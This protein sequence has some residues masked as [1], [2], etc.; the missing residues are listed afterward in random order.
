M[1]PGADGFRPLLLEAPTT[2]PLAPLPDD[3]RLGRLLE[4][5]GKAELDALAAIPGG[6]APGT[7][8]RVHRL[9]DLEAIDGSPLAGCP[10]VLSHLVEYQPGELAS[11]AAGLAVEVASP[12]QLAAALASPADLLIGTGLE[13]P[14]PA[15]ET[16][17]MV[18][19]QLLA[20]RA[21]RP[22]YLAIPASPELAAALR[23]EGASGL[24]L[25]ANLRSRQESLSRVRVP[26]GGGAVLR[27]AMAADPE[28]LRDLEAR[29]GRELGELL[30]TTRSEGLWDE[31]LEDVA[32]SDP[33]C[34]V[35]LAQ[36]FGAI[37]A[38]APCRSLFAAGAPGG[39]REPGRLPVVQGPLSRISVTAE[40]AAAVHDAGAFPYLALAGL[41]FETS[42]ALVRETRARGF[43]FGVGIV[44]LAEDP[45]GFERLVRMLEE[46]RPDRVLVA[47]P[48]MDH[49]DRL[50]ATGLELWV[51]A[52]VASVFRALASMGVTR[53]VV[54]GEE[55][56]G[57]VSAT[58]A[59]VAWDQVLREVRAQGLADRVEI[60]FAGGVA[61]GRAAHLLSSLLWFHG[62]AGRLRASLHVGT[63]YLATG[64]IVASTPLGRWYQKRVVEEDETFVTGDTLRLRVR[65][66]RTSAVEELRRREW[67]VFLSDLPLEAKRKEI[68]RGYL[69]TLK[70]ALEADG[71]DVGASFMAGSA[72]A[73]ITRCRSLRELHEELTRDRLPG[74][75]AGRPEPIAV[76]GIGALL[77]GARD[78]AGFYRSVLR[79][80]CFVRDLP[81]SVW[82]RDV[83]LD[84]DA[85]APLRSYSGIA[86]LVGEIPF[87]PA[88]FRIPPSAAV[89]MDRAQK[90][91][92]VCAR[93]ALADA[94]Y[95]ERRF[96]RERVGVILANSMGGNAVDESQQTVHAERVRARLRELAR[97]KGA[98]ELVDELL[99]AYQDRFEEPEITEDTL[100]G[101]LSSLIA[102]RIAWA[103]D[104]HGPNFTVDSAC[105][106][107][108]AAVS[109][110][111][112]A[113]RARECDMVLSGGV[114]TQVDPGLFVKFSKLTA[115]SAEGSFPFDARA[116]GFVIGEGCAVFALKRWQDALLAGDP[117]YAVI[118]GFGASSDGAGKGITAP[119]TEGQLLAMTR[120]Y[121]DAGIDPRELDYVECHGT[122]TRLGD[123]T[124]LETVARL[125]R[126]RDPARGALPVGSV[127]A[128]VG[129]LKAAAGAAGLVQGLMA[130]N[131]RSVP[132]QVG[133]ET[134]NPNVAWRE[135]GIRVATRPESLPEDRPVK[136]GV[137]SFGFGGTNYHL[138]LESPPAGA[139]PARV[140][141]GRYAL[142]EL[143]PLGRDLALMFPGQGSQYLGM[144]EALRAAP[145][146]AEVLAEA[147]RCFRA[148]EG[149]RIS[150]VIWPA[151]RDAAAEVRLTDTR[152]AQPAIFTVSVMLLRELEAR[153]VRPALVMGHSL[154][155]YTALHA[156]G[157]LGFEDA[158]RAVSIRGR[159]M[160]EGAGADPG[161]MAFVAADEE[162][163]AGLLAG[164]SGYVVAANLN[165][166]E[167]TV[168]S[169][170]TAAVEAVVEAAERRGV[171]ARRLGV[172][173]AFHSRL[174][175]G[176]IPRMREVLEAAPLRAGAL[177]VPANLAGRVYPRVAAA[178]AGRPLSAGER[179]EVVELLTRQIDHPVDFVRQVEA[180]Y[181]AGI[182]RFLEVGPKNV[183]ARLVE[184]ILAGKA[185]TA[186]ATDKAGEEGTERFEAAVAGLGEP[187]RIARRPR[188]GEGSGAG[189]GARSGGAAARAA[190][191]A[192]AGG[193]GIG[194]G[195]GAGSQPGTEAGTPSVEARV[196][197]VVAS[198]SGYRA[199][200]IG[201]DAD[202]ERD[203]GIDTLKIFEILSR[204]RGEVLPPGTR[205]FRDLTTV[206]KIV[207]AAGPGGG[208]GAPATAGPGGVP[209]GEGG[210]FRVLVRRE[211][212][213]VLPAGPAWAGDAWVE[214]LPA[215][216]EPLRD[217]LF[218]RLRDRLAASAPRPLG[219][220]TWS[221][222]GTGSRA[223]RLAVAGFVRSAAKDVGEDRI[224][225]VH[226]E[227]DEPS[228]AAAAAALAAPGYGNRVVGSGKVSEARLVAVEAGLAPETT[229]GEALGP[230]DLILV[231]GGARGIAAEVVRRWLGLVDSRFVVLGR[232]PSGE[233]WIETEGR[234]RVRYVQADLTTSTGVAALAAAG[235]APTLVV[236]ASG[237]EVSRALAGKSDEE[238]RAVIDSKVAALDALS[239]AVRR[240][241]LR[242]VV[243]FSSVASHFGNH[244][245]AD[246]AAANGWLDGIGSPGLPSLSIGWTAWDEVGM[247]A[248]GPIREI[249]RERGI[250][251][252]PVAEGSRLAGSLVASWLGGRLPEG[253][254]GSVAVVV[255]GAIGPGFVLGRDRSLVVADGRASG[256][257]AAPGSGAGARAGAG[258]AA[259]PAGGI[260]AGPDAGPSVPRLDRVPMVAPGTRARFRYRF[261]LAASGYLKDHRINRHFYLP[262]VSV[263]RQFL[264]KLGQV[265]AVRDLE[266]RDLR[267][268]APVR[269]V[270][271]EEAE[272]QVEG[273]G[274]EYLLES[275][276]GER[277]SPVVSLGLRVNGA[278]PGD[279]EA[280]RQE[281]RELAEALSRP[282]GPWPATANRVAD[283]E[284]YKTYFHGP[285]FQ[286]LEALEGY[287]GRVLSALVSERPEL[288]PGNP[289]S[290]YGRVPLLLE[291]VFHA[292]GL[293]SLIDVDCGNYYIPHSV[294][295]CR[296]FLDACP[297]SGRVRVLARV[298]DWRE[299]LRFD[300]VVVDERGAPLLRV[301]ELVMAKSREPVPHRKAILPRDAVVHL[302]G[303]S[304]LL[305]DPAGAGSWGEEHR[306]RVFT[307][308]ESAELDPAATPERR[309]ERIA[310]RLAAKRLARSALA[311]KVHGSWGIESFEVISGG[312]PPAVSFLGPSHFDDMLADRHWSISH[313]EGLAAAAEAGV[314]VGIDVERVRPLAPEAARALGSGRSGERIR[315]RA[316]AYSGDARLSELYAQVFPLVAFTQKEAVLKAVGTGIGDGLD[317]VVLEDVELSTP[318]LATWRGRTFR[319]LSVCD[320]RHV[321]SVAVEDAGAGVRFP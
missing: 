278:G 283:S 308:R 204:L 154:G 55:A 193:S 35:R 245:Q 184:E 225:Y 130:V 112:A 150:E 26:L 275:V 118:R 226:I 189:I 33:A 260:P 273:R 199:E 129:H 258:V 9:A 56:G 80:R 176:S 265:Q 34:L 185:F 246:Y 232:K 79:R 194:S 158:L 12:A 173:A 241:R 132:P 271:G 214:A 237:L 13:R 192:G 230:D 290:E 136:V 187:V 50:L 262:G 183:L 39:P 77:P 143:G 17:G 93:E 229:L 284:I 206:A 23:A 288:G 99:A 190:R 153:G 53:F 175:A 231:S 59:L 14:G 43:P 81:D 297:G 292:C 1:K 238:I 321:V 116:D 285:A 105:A 269:F 157:V 256:E 94:G 156:A 311:E 270:D 249:L 172:A 103:F 113:L 131:T 36:V 58:P 6:P 152:F 109:V 248:R 28:R 38:E 145:R 169:G 73:L 125:V 218:P 208:A 4:V 89:R 228:P 281:A 147:D 221:R 146:A 276:Q 30:R 16:T 215:S 72:V 106:S 141:S 62:L 296:I 37:P 76:V 274:S 51:H 307:P 320:E 138:V 27:L 22:W 86:G 272:F 201:R 88:E 45:E 286:V 293:L 29:T 252:L 122:G 110:A 102:G 222:A 170:E 40:F 161:A 235:L 165:A 82:E 257:G 305:V 223:A 234:G 224:R 266:I 200:Q 263:V 69:G 240:D 67:S 91:A 127:K 317:E 126:G 294:S 299:R 244:G 162:T 121:R 44:T 302:G 216:I 96:E 52:P 142:P 18:L 70:K 267:F 236:H 247:A 298:L 182:R 75:S 213:G 135:V 42:D 98:G 124:E 318:R 48:Q 8:L 100:P 139:R 115:L 268:L 137:S 107:T 11:R 7:A 301:S 304:V 41:G 217:G 191:R 209:A 21:D 289:L 202:F 306:S 220:V 219:L 203:L 87:D 32:E 188:G 84:P 181:Q 5:F 95:R 300:A 250:E 253:A 128:T 68:E 167:Q 312:R 242:G 251:L 210:R 64:E 314:A 65:Q 205:N 10:V 195:V 197:G 74:P 134:P 133:F 164:V 279:R 168:V 119:R 319:V 49:V 211:V 60:A 2:G 212:E 57:H 255:A 313:T 177:P 277:T 303:A 63:A 160:A 261:D 295:G 196:V 159:A 316:A 186:L 233:P 174:V 66:V 117:V 179:A 111:M 140:A 180:A 310:G 97:E 148:I 83:F 19:F 15:R 207:E 291:A 151:V 78:A 3:A 108:L 46:V 259:G 90:M 178:E 24:V 20:E 280:A 123:A 243:S 149:C 309:R 254:P 47:A 31:A 198:V 54:E 264:K 104:L 85:S 239:G 144:G 71:S 120:A 101:E 92:L 282:E 25:P 163:V 287:D 227:G 315:E 166:Y 171:K 114:D 155:E 61:T